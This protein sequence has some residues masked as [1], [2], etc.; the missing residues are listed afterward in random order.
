MGSIGFL[1]DCSTISEGSFIPNCWLDII[2]LVSVSRLIAVRKGKIKVRRQFRLVRSD[3]LE[4]RP[5]D[6]RS[7]LLQLP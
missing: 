1:P 2:L 6:T 5:Y 7:F 3:V 4:P